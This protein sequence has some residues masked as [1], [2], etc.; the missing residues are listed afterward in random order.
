MRVNR[1]GYDKNA[2]TYEN[3]QK[4]VTAFNPVEYKTVGHENTDDVFRR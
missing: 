3:Y 1:I 4:M 2:V